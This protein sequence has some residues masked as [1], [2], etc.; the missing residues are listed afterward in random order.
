LQLARVLDDPA[1]VDAEKRRKRDEAT[2]SRVR[3]QKQVRAKWAETLGL[4]HLVCAVDGAGVAIWAHD[5]GTLSRSMRPPDEY[6]L[7]TEDHAIALR[8]L[9]GP[10]WTRD[11]ELRAGWGIVETPSGDWIL[12]HGRA[13]RLDWFKTPADLGMRLEECGN[14]TQ[15]MV[16]ASGYAKL[17]VLGCG[18][19]LC[20]VCLPK[21][22]LR[23]AAKLAPLLDAAREAGAHLVH[24]THTHRPWPKV[25]P[26]PPGE[27]VSLGVEVSGPACATLPEA[28]TAERKAWD[29]MNR[30]RGTEANAEFWEASVL[31]A[32][33][34][35]E[36]TERPDQ[37]GMRWHSHSHAI[38]I[39]DPSQDVQ[40]GAVKLSKKR[41]PVAKAKGRWVDR[42][43]AVWQDCVNAVGA[44]LTFSNQKASHCDD[45]GGLMEVLKYPAKLGDLSPGAMLQWAA[46]APSGRLRTVSGVLHGGHRNGKRAKMLAAGDVESDG[47]TDEVLR[48]IGLA[49]EEEEE[50]QGDSVWLWARMPGGW[51][52]VTES[53]LERLQSV[54]TDP[55]LRLTIALLPRDRSAALDTLEHIR[56]E[57]KNIAYEI[58]TVLPSIVADFCRKRLDWAEVKKTEL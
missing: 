9:G 33:V 2:R 25:W 29:M 50:A 58:A 27:W 46:Y 38:V 13:R 56:S 55:H 3:K 54:Y 5:D 8:Q 35:F 20:A 44:T 32:L 47:P 6:C 30:G 11:T 42:W 17:I 41:S 21:R 39:V 4:S 19:V 24:C 14:S 51:D 28:L 15:F 45:F 36:V 1:S 34:G 37:G 23:R 53:L 31:G 22:G 7:W 18:S 26:T 12:C 40:R 57:Q 48:A 43:R 10:G 16:M 52:R 49:M